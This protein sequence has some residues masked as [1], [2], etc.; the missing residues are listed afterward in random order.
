MMSKKEME[1][2]LKEYMH[3]ITVWYN[4]CRYYQIFHSTIYYTILDYHK[5]LTIADNYCFK[6]LKLKEQYEERNAKTC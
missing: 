2:Q 4:I 6:Y 1:V 3:L 5:A